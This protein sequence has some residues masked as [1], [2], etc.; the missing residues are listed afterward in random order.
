GGGG[1]PHA[2][3]SDD[4][5]LMDCQMSELDGRGAAARIRA[6]EDGR[7]TPIIA[8]TASAMAGDRER[9]LAA[10]MDDHLPKPVGL[11]QLEA[12]LRRVGRAEE[13]PVHRGLEGTPAESVLD[14]SV[15]EE[16]RSLGSPETV[17]ASVS[18]F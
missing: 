12:A 7:R 3:R 4:V 5:I 18:L 8:L 15:L 17:L 13:R 16:L 10:G 6:G 11:A 9:S 1:G 2:P 14:P